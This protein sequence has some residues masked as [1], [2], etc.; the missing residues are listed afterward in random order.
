MRHRTLAV[1][2]A[3]AMLTALI[4]TT[5]LAAD[6][7]SPSD[8]F[9]SEYV[10]GSSF[11]KAI[12][13][14]N[15]TGAPVDL[16][17][18]TIEVYFNGS[19][20]ANTTIELTGTLEPGEVHVVADDGADQ[21][22]LDVAD[23]TSTSNFW[24]GNDA[25]VLTS[26]AGT[27]DAFG[28]VGFDPGSQW[29]D[30]NTGAQEATL[31]RMP[32]VCIGDTDS[33][34]AFDPAAEWDGFSQDT[35]DGLGSHAV[36]CEGNGDP[37]EPGEI[38]ALLL[39]TEL[40]VTPTGGEF[41]EIHNPGTE[42]VDLSD[43]YLTD[44]TF[45]PGGAF[46]YNIVT[47]SNVGGG[48]FA[49]FHARFPDGASIDGGAYQTIA[50]AGSDDYASAYG[51]NPDY[52]LF[53]DGPA[54]DDIPD[55]REALPGSVDGQGGLTNAGE[56]AVLYQWDGASD[57]VTDLDYALWGDK[58]EAIDKTDVATDGPDAD[59]E[60]TGYAPDTPIDD[61]EVIATGAHAS[62][63]SYQRV[64]LTEGTEVTSG[65]NGFGGADE[66]S[67][68]LS[69]TWTTG[70]P[71]PGV[72]VG[73]EPELECDVSELTLVSEVQGD[74]AVSPLAGDP[75]FEPGDRVTV[76]AVVTLV[77]PGLDGF[78]VQEESA[79]ND[80][81]PNTSEGLFVAGSV[82][83]GTEAGDTV[84]VTGGASEEF[85]RT[86]INANS[87]VDCERDPV[88]IDP[89]GLTL[90]ADTAEREKLEG[91]VVETTQDLFVSSLFTAYEF[92]ELGVALDGPLTQPTSAFA[93]DDP[94]AQQLADDNAETLLFIDDRDEF[95]FQN[96]PWFDDV[97]RRAG[98]VVEAGAV[99]ALNFSFGNFLLEPLDDFPEIVQ[100]EM[101]PDAPALA[102]GND[103]GAFN[104][105]NYFNT[106]GDTDV[107]RGARNQA[108]FDL[109][110][111]KIV[112]AILELDTAI[113]GLIELENDYEDHYDGDPETVPSIQTLVDQLN[114][115]AGAGTYDWIVPP[116]SIL[117]DEGLG[118][119]GLGPDAIAQGII[120]QPARVAPVGEAATF[121]IDAD[122][123]ELEEIDGE[124][125]E[126]FS[127]GD[128]NRWPLAQSFEVDGQVVT[129]VVNHFKSKGSS[130]VGVDGPEFDPG[131]D[132]ETFL[133]GNCNLTR[134]YAAQQLMEWVETKPTEVNSPDTFV[135]GDLNSYDE[136]GPIEAFIDAGYEDAV[137]SH[138]NDAFTFKFD[139]RYG[140]LDY[141]MAS[142]SAK[143][144]LEDAAVWQA[145]SPEPYGYLYF[146]DPVETPEEATAYAS[147]DHDPV[148][149]AIDPPGRSGGR[150]G[151]PPGPPPGI[152]RGPGR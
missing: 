126:S 61:Q 52:E 11:N 100:V 51:A 84:E 93:P 5:A 110:S 149:V 1:L 44:A 10:E 32:E 107:L 73:E 152:G 101:R 63:Q 102:E 46:Y 14:Y 36:D 130:C 58:E 19:T 82:P 137:H 117:T 128:K 25:I 140:R 55:M 75:P 143:R 59:S 92:G 108:Q 41:I 99:G 121:D 45:A 53:E 90:P 89:T 66:T 30:G 98:D 13:L 35:F 15:G 56:V 72:A 17:D 97:R 57:I 136:E 69:G 111:A 146:I 94:Q 67:E 120:Y 27:V 105:L 139:G 112:E 135:V 43:V 127:D 145:N 29:G 40:V 148:I 125:N 16:S 113:L 109:Q 49:D 42:P 3:L 106:F 141:V 28:Q 144:L 74:G 83:A 119:G 123:T 20:S 86:Q 150:G 70:S 37:G 103:I 71:T 12:E 114:E 2:S 91:M 54:S 9:I 62:G 8:L 129:V 151:G 104:V 133:T 65:G 81:D 21:A 4:P 132:V 26:S 23:Q 18:Y 68:N 34:D 138:G 47:G 39:L 78:F 50:V 115:R 95:G 6:G 88:T 147:S 118:G 38:T 96:A 134:E 87:V 77:A 33:S 124:P 85:E 142:P 80:G 122:L 60:P 76:Q 116:E 79:D 22:I 64:D 31:R 7:E 48:G 24:N 131:D